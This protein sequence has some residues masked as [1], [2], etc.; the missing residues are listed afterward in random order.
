MLTQLFFRMNEMDDMLEW[1]QQGT[2]SH[3]ELASQQFAL[4]QQDRDL[5]RAKV[6]LF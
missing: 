2:A 4:R 6:S 1:V 3:V 5:I